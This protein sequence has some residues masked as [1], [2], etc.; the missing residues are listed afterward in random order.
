MRSADKLDTALPIN[1]YTTRAGE[2][3]PR[4]VIYEKKKSVK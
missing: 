1:A 3:S 2:L 4:A